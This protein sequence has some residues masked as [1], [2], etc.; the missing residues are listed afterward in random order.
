MDNLLNLAVSEQ[1]SE[2]VRKNFI[3][4]LAPDCAIVPNG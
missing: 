2:W 4:V 3:C 1:V